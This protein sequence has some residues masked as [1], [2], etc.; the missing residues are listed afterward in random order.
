MI[1]YFGFFDDVEKHDPNDETLWQIYSLRNNCS[2]DLQVEMPNHFWNNWW[3]ETGYAVY[4]NGMCHWWG[5]EDYFGDEVL[6]SFNLSDEV[7]MTT[8]FNHNYGKFAKHMVVLKESIAMIEYGDS[9]CF[10]ISIL[11]EFGV[12]ESWTRLFSIGPLSSVVEPIGVGKNGDIFYINYNEEVTR[13]DLNT[14]VIEDIPLKEDMN[15][16]KWLFI[17]KVFF[18][19]EEYIVNCHILLNVHHLSNN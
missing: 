2:R 6:V 17:M 7:F 8:P 18:Q 15:V 12:A 1:R 3:Q 19:S 5:S 4:F 10:F 11:G 9:P 16:V 14:E 13:F